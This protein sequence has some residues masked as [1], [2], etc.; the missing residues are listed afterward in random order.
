MKNNLKLPAHPCKIILQ[1]DNTHEEGTYLYENPGFTKLELAS[2]M[3]MQGMLSNSLPLDQGYE[4]LHHLLPEEMAICAVI[5]G[6]AV[7]EEANK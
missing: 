4:P 7:I 6:K 1:T 3:A 5:Y 2:L